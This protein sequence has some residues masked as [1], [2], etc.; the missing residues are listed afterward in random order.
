[1]KGE[2]AMLA[3]ECDGLHGGWS[4]IEEG[5]KEGRKQCDA[6]DRMGG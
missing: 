4:K 1:M 2:G 5:R 6:V 3:K